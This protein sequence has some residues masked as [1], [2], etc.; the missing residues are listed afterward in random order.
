MLRLGKKN[1]KREFHFTFR[2]KFGLNGQHLGGSK[3]WAE[4]LLRKMKHRHHFYTTLM[5]QSRHMVEAIC[6]KRKLYILLDMMMMLQA[7]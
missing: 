7:A 5:I 6:Q 2:S 1:E 3:I 4:Q